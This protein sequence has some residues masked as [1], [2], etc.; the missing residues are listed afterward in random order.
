MP[1]VAGEGRQQDQSNQSL[2]LGLSYLMLRMSF[3]LG[4]KKKKKDFIKRKIC[5]EK[6]P[7]AFSS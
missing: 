1:E 4:K 5:N 2:T 6:L 7:A 3:L